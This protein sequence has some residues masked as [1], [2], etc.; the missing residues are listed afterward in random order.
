MSCAT[1]RARETAAAHANQKRPLDA[2]RLVVC[3]QAADVESLTDPS[4]SWLDRSD[5]SDITIKFSNREIKCHR[6]ILCA[7]SEYFKEMIGSGICFAV[8]NKS[9]KTQGKE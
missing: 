7:R 6:V 1:N 5:F 2:S 4:I 8:S 3:P 9:H